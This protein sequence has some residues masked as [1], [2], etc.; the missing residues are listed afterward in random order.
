MAVQQA[1]PA[2]TR[3]V[4]TKKA[5]P[6]KAVAT[7]TAAKTGATKETAMKTVGVL[8]HDRLGDRVA[9]GEQVV[10]LLEVA[11]RHD[12]LLVDGVIV[13]GSAGHNRFDL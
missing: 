8:S 11:A 1:T 12:L 3:G 10:D 7:K 5:V 6:T 13:L 2:A 4:S 9:D